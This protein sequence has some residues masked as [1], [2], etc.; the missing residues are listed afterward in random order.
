MMAARYADSQ[1]ERARL[2]ALAGDAFEAGWRYIV[3]DSQGY[4]YHNAKGTTMSFTG[5]G[6]WMYHQAHLQGVEGGALGVAR[7]GSG[8]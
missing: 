4:V 6:E 5:G 8:R 3:G 1:E 7:P 2:V